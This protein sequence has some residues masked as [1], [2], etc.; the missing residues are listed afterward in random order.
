LPRALPP[1]H[2][3][4]RKYRA[5]PLSGS[6]EQGTGKAA[7]MMSRGSR[8]MYVLETCKPVEGSEVDLA[9]FSGWDA[10]PECIFFA[11]AATTIKK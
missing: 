1:Q 9:C 3:P 7:G 10:R 11:A 6:G 5:S 8:V 2:T 4:G